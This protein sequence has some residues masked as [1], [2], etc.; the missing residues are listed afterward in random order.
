MASATSGV[1]FLVMSLIPTFRQMYD[2]HFDIKHLEI[3][4]WFSLHLLFL[5]F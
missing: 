4:F 5:S 1:V 2:V 3:F